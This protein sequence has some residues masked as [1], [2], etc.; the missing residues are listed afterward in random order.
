MYLLVLLCLACA[1]QSL[2]PRIQRHTLDTSPILLPLL[3]GEKEI[4][5][6]LLCTKA[7]RDVTSYRDP[8]NPKVT[9]KSSAEHI[10]TRMSSLEELFRIRRV[11][12]DV[13]EVWRSEPF[14][15]AG[16]EI[17]KNVVKASRRFAAN[18]VA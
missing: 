16:A 15:V 13:R 4:P 10:H 18:D 9:R 5:I 14:D 12:D 6:D 17:P 1:P 3:L 11:C 7:P 2:A 8:R